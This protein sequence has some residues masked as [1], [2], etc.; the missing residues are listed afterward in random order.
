MRVLIGTDRIG[1]LASA[2]AGAALGRAFLAAR[3]GVEV[4]VVPMGSGGP[5]LAAALAALGDDSVVVG[6]P[7]AGRTRGVH[8]DHVHGDEEPTG[9]DVASTSLGVGQALAAALSS[10]PRRVV[11]DLTGLITHDGGAGILAALGARADVPLDRGVGALGGLGSIDL[12][13]A[14]ERVGATEL[15]AVI[16]PGEL[17]DLLLGLRGLTSRRGRAAGTDPAVMLAA[18]AALGSLAS[19]L[20]IP[21]APGL[22]AAGGA[23]LAL[24]ALGAWTTGGPA[25]CAQIAH[26]ERTAALADVVITG[27]DQVDF[28]TR[29]GHVVPEMAAIAQRSMRPAVV[30]ARE[31]AVSGR[32]LRTF[33]VEVAYPLGGDAG[34]SADEL[35]ERAAGVARSW[36]W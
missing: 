6:D 30:V 8:H 1:A 28:A 32:E 2:D 4:A 33:G 18:D 15:V 27:A 26:L 31:V 10:R 11:V 29:G 3:P 5:D 21:D 9:V 16:D 20:G 13:L 24:T 22:G 34:L 25:L 7:D 19:A 23:V 17:G 36:T 12:A 14:R 35:T